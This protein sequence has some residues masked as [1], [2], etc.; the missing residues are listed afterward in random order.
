MIAKVSSL[1]ACWLLSCPTVHVRAF[2]SIRLGRLFRRQQTSPFDRRANSNNGSVQAPIPIVDESTVS[3]AVPVGPGLD[4][5]PDMHG[6]FETIQQA[7]PLAKLVIEREQRNGLVG[8]NAGWHND[9]KRIATTKPK[10][11]QTSLFHVDDDNNDNAMSRWK[12]IESNNRGSRPI[13]SIERWDR[14]Q[15]VDAPLLR[16]RASLEGPCVAD[17]LASLIM[18]LEER[19]K[20]DIQIQDVYEAYAIKDLA[21][22]NAAMGFEYGN[23]YRLGVG[24][25]RTKKNLG[26]DARE[27]LTLCGINQFADGSSMIWGVELPER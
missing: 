11:S 9:R 23:C 13:T 24:Y 1:A 19:S 18:I 7:S 26:I 21:S 22:A 25:C 16:F 8:I 15:N 6:L 17:P 3:A 5:L 12:S 4:L 2:R 10:E 14:F 27:Q 20:W